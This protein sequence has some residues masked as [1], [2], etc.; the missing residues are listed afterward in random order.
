MSGRESGE[1]GCDGA[2]RDRHLV[3]DERDDRRTGRVQTAASERAFAVDKYSASLAAFKKVARSESRPLVDAPRV[4]CCMAR[5][6]ERR[7]RMSRSPEAFSP[8]TVR[9]ADSP[10]RASASWSPVTAA[11]GLATDPSDWASPSNSTVSSDGDPRDFLERSEPWWR[12]EDTL[13][14]ADGDDTSPPHRATSLRAVDQTARRRLSFLEEEVTFLADR[15]AHLESHRP[16]EC[17]AESP[18]A[19][20]AFAAATVAPRRADAT[21]ANTAANTTANPSSFED[22]AARSGSAA[23][24][25]STHSR[26]AFIDDHLSLTISN[27]SDLSGCPSFDSAAFPFSASP[28]R[29]SAETPPT[30]PQPAAD[31]ESSPSAAARASDFDFDPLSVHRARGR[32]LLHPSPIESKPP[33][34]GDGDSPVDSDGGSSFVTAFE[35]VAASSEDPAWTDRVRRFRKCQEELRDVKLELAS[36]RNH[37]AFFGA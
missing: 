10:S 1:G 2:K 11:L 6:R 18:G 15:V 3:A 37:E 33:N 5:S 25:P 29:A 16:A 7:P 20:V 36:L 17:P 23:S 24:T 26:A 35:F 34:G 21:T 28:S 27:L 9:F 8:S 14:D 4:A 31:D 19:L 13:S 30:T 32:R 12:R 22:V